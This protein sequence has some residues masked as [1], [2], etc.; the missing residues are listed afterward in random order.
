MTASGGTVTF[1]QDG[2]TFHTQS[3]T[4]S[5]TYY[6]FSTTY[7]TGKDGKFILV[8]GSGSSGGT[9][10]PPPPAFVRI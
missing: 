1:A 10:L 3:A 2:T 6:P 9:R 7:D 8:S 4:T 5:G